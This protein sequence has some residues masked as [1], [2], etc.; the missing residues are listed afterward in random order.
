MKEENN[1]HDGFKVPPGYFDQ[2]NRNVLNK[3]VHL[4]DG[5]NVPEGY[6]E[7]L[8][9]AI[10]LRKNRDKKQAPPQ[11]QRNPVWRYAAAAAVII[12]VNIALYFI[13]QPSD[14]N[15]VL[16]KT[17]D[18][19]L[20]QYLEQNGTIDDVY[21]LPVDLSQTENTESIYLLFES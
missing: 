15:T 2:M 14:F 6:F 8:K 11:L 1:I 12:S 17:E 10:Q 20:I 9:Q 18:A 19:V 5:F 3:T 21:H 4:N 16:Q 13:L 7:H